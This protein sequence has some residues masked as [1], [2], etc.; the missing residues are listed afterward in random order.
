MPRKAKAK[1][2][3]TESSWWKERSK[4]FASI[5]ESKPAKVKRKTAKTKKSMTKKGRK[6]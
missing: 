6:K 3:S 2:A 5:K 4:I 1:P